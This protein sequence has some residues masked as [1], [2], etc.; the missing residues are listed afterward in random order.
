MNILEQ[1]KNFYDKTGGDMF[2]DFSAYAGQGYVFVTPQTLLF[3]KA[4]RTDSDIHPNNQWNVVAPDAWFVKTAI[5]EDAISEFIN[6]IPYPLPFVGWMRELKK[7]PVKWYDF[8][9]IMRRK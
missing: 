8:N 6:R 3:G 5:G 9:R 2:E 4:V 7:K 1:T